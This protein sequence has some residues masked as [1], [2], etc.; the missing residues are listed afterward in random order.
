MHFQVFVCNIERNKERNRPRLESEM[1][2]AQAQ[3]P[4]HEIKQF[5]HIF[6]AIKFESVWR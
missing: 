3:E 2:F 4:L 6:R 1:L 5:Y